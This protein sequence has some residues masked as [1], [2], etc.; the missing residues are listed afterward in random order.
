MEFWNRDSIS[1]KQVSLWCLFFDPHPSNIDRCLNKNINWI[2]LAY[3]NGI[4]SSWSLL[5]TWSLA[6]A[7]DH[8]HPYQCCASR[9][10]V[11]VNQIGLS[12]R[13]NYR[14]RVYFS[15]IEHGSLVSCRVVVGSSENNLE[16]ANS[17]FVKL[18][19]VSN[20][21]IDV[22]AWDAYCFRVFMLDEWEVRLYMI[23]P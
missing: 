22:T 12:E 2:W 13:G 7:C 18:I 17:G 16:H 6:R 5:I 3:L 21:L 8:E 4:S 1:S 19:L 9:C 11:N 15:S 23:I 14:I 20:Q 10:H